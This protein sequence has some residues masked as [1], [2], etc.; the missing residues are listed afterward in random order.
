[1]VVF[2]GARIEN[3]FNTLVEQALEPRQRLLEHLLKEEK[4]HEDEGQVI[5]ILHCL[6]L[7]DGFLQR[8][9]E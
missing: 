2:A 9:R 5:H 6:G 3:S 8:I 7:I 4:V 1:M